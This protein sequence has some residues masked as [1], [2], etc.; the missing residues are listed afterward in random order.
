MLCPA[1]CTSCPSTGDPVLHAVKAAIQDKAINSFFI[2]YLLLKNCHNSE[3]GNRGWVITQFCVISTK[4]PLQSR[5]PRPWPGTDQMRSAARALPPFESCGCWSRR[6]AHRAPG[7]SAFIAR[8]IEQPGSRHSNPAALKKWCVAL[9][10]RPAP[11]PSQKRAPPSPVSHCEATRLTQAACTTAAASRK[12][13]MRLLV[14]EPINTLSIM[15]RHPSRYVGLKPHVRAARA[16]IALRLTAWHLSLCPGRA[17]GRIHAH[18]HL[19]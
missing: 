16:A 4:T 1:F 6:S 2:K 8:H 10:L 18:H 11:S 9:Q 13:S 7:L 14:Q 12:S 19:R 5:R 15:D 17:H 3:N